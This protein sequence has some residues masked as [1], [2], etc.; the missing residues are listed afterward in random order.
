MLS[1]KPMNLEKKR[2]IVNEYNETIKKLH[3]VISNMK[4]KPNKEQ[5]KDAIHFLEGSA[6]GLKQAK[7]IFLK[8]DN[9]DD[10]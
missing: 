8:I 10:I 6:S 2:K 3:D 9:E 5:C 4:K 1:N 7:K